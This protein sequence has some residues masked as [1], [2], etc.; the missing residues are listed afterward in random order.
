MEGPSTSNKSLN[1]GEN[2][3]CDSKFS[4]NSVSGE[5]RR[6]LYLAVMGGISPSAAFSGVVP[7]ALHK[8]ERRD[9]EGV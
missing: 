1:I 2:L 3:Y 5:R 7:I 6:I 4:Q 9:S 8:G